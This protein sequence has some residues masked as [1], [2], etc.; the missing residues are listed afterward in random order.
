MA[1]LRSAASDPIL[2]NVLTVW[3]RVLSGQ[4]CCGCIAVA[5][6]PHCRTAP[7]FCNAPSGLHRSASQLNPN[8]KEWKPGSN[9]SF[10]QGAGNNKKVHGGAPGE[11]SGSIGQVLNEV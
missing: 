3:G 8:A 7:L 6:P 1:V 11:R 5:P 2:S 10:Q 9:F 4:S